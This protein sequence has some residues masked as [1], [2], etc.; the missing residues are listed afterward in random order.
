[1]PSQDAGAST[2]LAKNLVRVFPCHLTEDPHEL[3]GQS[4]VKGNP[5]SP[6][7]L[8]GSPLGEGVL[9][10]WEEETISYV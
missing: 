3:L 6:P 1:M 10:T 9:P 7:L 8:T 4:N 2:G 5:T